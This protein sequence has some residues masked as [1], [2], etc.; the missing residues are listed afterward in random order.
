MTGQ[1]VLEKAVIVS[2]VA[3]TLTLATG[4]IVGSLV[5]RQ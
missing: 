3:L 1:K 2:V 4:I 5:W